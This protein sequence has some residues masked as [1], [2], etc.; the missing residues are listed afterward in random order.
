V[1]A[2]LDELDEEL[3]EAP[4]WPLVLWV[5]VVTKVLVVVPAPVPA[6]P[7]ATAPPEALPPSPEKL[8]AALAPQPTHVS[9]I[10]L[11][12]RRRKLTS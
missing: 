11:K 12:A 1:V 4:P 2:P 8:L 5:D 6:P 10:K 3:V 9:P 7:K